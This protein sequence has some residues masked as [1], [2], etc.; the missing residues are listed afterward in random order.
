M[1]KVS[2][3]LM[4]LLT[5]II[6]ACGGQ[7]GS[8]GAA[9]VENYMQA[10]VEGDADTIR[11]LL[12]SEMEQF[13]EREIH[14]FDSVEGVRLEEMS[15]HDAAAGIVEC[16]GKIVARYGAE[17]TEFPLTAYRIVEE[18]GEWKWCGETAVTE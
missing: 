8:G 10:K 15:C 16:S 14:T 2:L 18:D 3:L 5:A 13:A 7:S 9:A 4:G 1:K 12:C 11:T 6:A 17:D